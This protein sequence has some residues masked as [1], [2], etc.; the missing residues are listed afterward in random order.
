MAPDRQSSLSVAAGFLKPFF[1]D[2]QIP[3]LF[4]QSNKSKG[5]A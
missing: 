2:L 1:E 4:N 5:L 3:I